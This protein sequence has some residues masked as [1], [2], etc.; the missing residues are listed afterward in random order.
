MSLFAT[1][2]AFLVFFSGFAVAQISA[3]NCTSSTWEW[4]YNSIGQNPCIVAAYMLST[5]KGGSYAIGALPTGSVY[6]GPSGTDGAN[7]CMCSTVGYSLLSACGGCQGETW[8]TWSEYSFNCTKT[9]PA[10]QFPNPIPAGTCAP[11]WALLD[12][13]NENGWDFN[14]SYATGGT[15]ELGPGT[16]LGSSGTSSTSAS[17]TIPGP[18]SASVSDSST[19]NTATPKATPIPIGGHGSKAGLITGGIVGGIAAISLLVAAFF[20]RRRR[21]SRASFAA[22]SAPES[23]GDSAFFA[24]N[25]PMLSQIPSRA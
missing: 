11:K 18:A 12:V 2:L 15:P 5:C 19:P 24:Y 8:I 25:T 7:L 10:S 13:T 4:S 6:T 23:A 3:P 20:Y 16:I 17:S 21:R 9:L 22:R 1:P 14:K